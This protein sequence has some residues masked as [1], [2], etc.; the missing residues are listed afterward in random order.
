MAIKNALKDNEENARKNRPRS[1]KDTVNMEKEADKDQMQEQR[2]LAEQEQQLKARAFPLDLQSTEE[3]RWIHE[4]IDIKDHEPSISIYTEYWS[5]ERRAAY[6]IQMNDLQKR[7][8]YDEH[9]KPTSEQELGW[10]SFPRSL[11][12]ETV[13]YLGMKYD[14]IV[15]E[16]RE[17]EE[18]AGKER[19]KIK[20]I[21][22]KEVKVKVDYSSDDDVDFGSAWQQKSKRTMTS[23]PPDFEFD[24]RDVTDTELSDDD[25]DRCNAEHY[26][27]HFG[28]GEAR[29]HELGRK[30]LAIVKRLDK[31]KADRK[32][33]EDA[34][35]K[36]VDKQ[37]GKKRYKKDLCEDG[38]V[39]S[40][41]GP[42]EQELV[43]KGYDLGTANEDD[44]GATDM[45]LYMYAAGTYGKSL[46]PASIT[47]TEAPL[48]P[49]CADTMIRKERGVMQ[50]RGG[51]F[52]G[53][54]NY[55]GMETATTC[56]GTRAM[57]GIATTKIAERGPL[58]QRDAFVKTV[59]DANAIKK[60][61]D[62]RG[63][64][65]DYG[66][67]MVDKKRVQSW[68]D[69]RTEARRTKIKEAKATTDAQL[70]KVKPEVKFVEAQATRV[71]ELKRADPE[72][73]PTEETAL[74]MATR[75]P[76]GEG[77]QNFYKVKQQAREKAKI[78][79]ML[80][81]WETNGMTAELRFPGGTEQ[82]VQDYVNGIMD[83][84]L[85]RECTVYI[86]MPKG[87]Y[88]HENEYEADL[89]KHYSPSIQYDIN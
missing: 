33:K 14:R 6:R 46:C 4:N 18:A 71:P 67:W 78:D 40:N 21:N 24:I 11:G 34:E 53:C 82:E 80:G 1:S 19:R 2:L 7:F 30:A 43:N 64:D 76:A 75:A 49:E 68:I 45:G 5:E 28:P 50:G 62:K 54:C 15:E 32:K 39:E 41:P 89:G 51:V 29:Q 31:K 57:S 61:A 3:I 26:L 84:I 17:R 74:A 16:E 9:E 13:R 86:V 23:P 27:G 36:K 44:E 8:T 55:Q 69:A 83:D 85:D 77:V 52:W 63:K 60:G 70:R 66:E 22:I 38:D 10:V 37:R 12:A 81:V 20:E 65:I 35:K 56:R 58:E 25:A 48:C 79:G 42:Q 73:N 87:G 72:V 88:V 59:S 47:N